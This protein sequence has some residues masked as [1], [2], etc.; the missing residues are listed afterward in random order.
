MDIDGLGAK[1]MIQLVERDL[2]REPADIYRLDVATLEGLDR[3]GRKSAENLFAS[4]QAA[5][6]RSLA[7]LIHGLGIRHVGFTT[8]TDLSAWLA[9]ELP[10]GDDETD[11]AW[12]RRAVDRLRDASVEE[13]TEVYGIGQVVAESLARYFDDEVT[14]DT[15][16]RLVDAGVTAEAPA[17]GAPAEPSEGPL[18]GKT[19]VVTGTLPGFSRE[20]AEEAIRVAGGHAASSVSKKTDFLVAGE[21]AG[22]KL[23]KAE[24]LGV[25]I[26]DEDG[27]RALLG[28]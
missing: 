23:A 15:L 24:S 13:L 28:G 26:L 18:S 25:P 14:R 21:K 22:S 8:A 3:L 17:P 16:H 27:F 10:R 5:R 6:Q 20:E 11:G 19:L 12:T 1:I 7:R 9:R 2:V 4:I